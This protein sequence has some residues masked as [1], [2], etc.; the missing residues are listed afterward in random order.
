MSSF[1][2]PTVPSPEAERLYEADR[3]RL[4]HVANYTRLFARRPEVYAAWAELNGAIKRRMDPRRYELVTV[5]AARELRSS[6]CVLAHSKVLRDLGVGEGPLR[7]LAG[8]LVTA[9]LDETEVAVVAFAAKA[10][11]GAAG[12]T[13]EDVEELRRHGLD[14][15][16]V[17]DVA[18]AVGARGFFST[19]LDATGTRA[20]AELAGAFDPATR[21]ALA[22]GRAAAAEQ[23]GGSAPGL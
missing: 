14:D 7:E 6:Y 4:G 21:E 3:A 17:L 22:V 18:L 19:V 2:G 23:D 9:E 11:R 20:D 13:E 15:G 10:A 12:I 8:G 16:E 1:L 5:A